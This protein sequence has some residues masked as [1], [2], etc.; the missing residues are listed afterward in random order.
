MPAWHHSDPFFSG[1]KIMPDHTRYDEEELGGYIRGYEGVGG[2]AQG[3]QR[4]YCVW[5]Y[6]DKDW[7]VIKTQSQE[8]FYCG[9]PPPEKGAFKGEIKRKFCVPIPG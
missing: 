1:Y 9:D 8:G 7:V 6:G 2:V 5:Q 3:G 4:G